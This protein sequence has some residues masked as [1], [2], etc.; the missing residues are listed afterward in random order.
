MTPFPIF[1]GERLMGQA[2]KRIMALPTVTV[3]ISLGRADLP[4][5][6][7]GDVPR[8]AKKRVAEVLTNQIR[9]IMKTHL[10]EVSVVQFRHAWVLHYVRTCPLACIMVLCGS[11]G[12]N[13]G[14]Q[15]A[16]ADCGG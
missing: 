11:W 15:A 12:H 5:G 1:A 10:K 13:G 2:K 4:D 9:T 16:L 7:I 6:Y 14:A 3:P 8:G